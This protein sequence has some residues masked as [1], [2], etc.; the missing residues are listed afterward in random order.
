[1][2]R[3]HSPHHWIPVAIVIAIALLTLTEVH[4]QRTDSSAV[5]QGRPAMAG[6]QAGA[7]AMAGPPQGGIG[8]QGQDQSQINLRRS[9]TSAENMPQGEPAATGN[10]DAISANRAVREDKD[11]VK[12]DRDSGVKKD[13]RSVAQRAKN[14]VKR[15]VQRARHGVSDRDIQTADGQ[16]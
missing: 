11:I 12:R 15:I 3:Y 16:K 2:N 9:P 6:A 10:T 14:A 5:F 13:Q 4:G 7:G 1:M 8:V